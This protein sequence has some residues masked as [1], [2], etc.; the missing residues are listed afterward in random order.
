MKK[1]DVYFCPKCGRVVDREQRLSKYYAAACAFCDEDFFAIE[2]K[3]RGYIHLNGI[4][5]YI[6][7]YY[8]T[9]DWE[10]DRYTIKAIDTKKD[11]EYSGLYDED[12]GCVAEDGLNL[13]KDDKQIESVILQVFE[14]ML[15]GIFVN[16]EGK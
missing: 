9:I 11:K 12:G 2:L 14:N 15:R 6:L 7:N 13:P 16:L 3:K 5:F 4:N 1:T 8:V 10:D